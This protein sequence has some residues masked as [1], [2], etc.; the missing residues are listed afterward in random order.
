[1]FI[2][3]SEE[4]GAIKITKLLEYIHLFHT[5]KQPIRKKT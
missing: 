4:W 5:T 2:T 3:D 1:M